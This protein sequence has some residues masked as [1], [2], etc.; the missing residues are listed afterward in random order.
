MRMTRAFLARKETEF[1]QLRLTIASLRDEL[2][3]TRK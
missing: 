2:A 3:D 1:E